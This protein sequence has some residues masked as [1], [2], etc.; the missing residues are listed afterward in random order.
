MAEITRRNAEKRKFCEHCGEFVAFRTYRHHIQIF[1]DR[2]GAEKS[3]RKQDIDS[4][5]SDEETFAAETSRG[6][7]HENITQFRNTGKLLALAAIILLYYLKYSV[8]KRV[9]QYRIRSAANVCFILSLRGRR[10][11]KKQDKHGRQQAG[12]KCKKCHVNY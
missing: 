7:S 4:S 6:N 9:L 11:F 2:A 8:V 5:G 10:R 12:V 1:G 3:C